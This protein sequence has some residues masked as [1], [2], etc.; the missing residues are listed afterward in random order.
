VGTTATLQQE[1]EQEDS[2]SAML[3]PDKLKPFQQ[4][5]TSMQ[6]K[7]RKRDCASTVRRKMSG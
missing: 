5:T 1:E 7:P 6:K 2:P 4:G 3:L